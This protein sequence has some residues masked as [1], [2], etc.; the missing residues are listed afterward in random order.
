MAKDTA[1]RLVWRELVVWIFT[2]TLV[3]D[4]VLGLRDLPDIMVV[5]DHSREQ[6]V[7][8]PDAGTSFCKGADHQTMLVGLGRF[9]HQSS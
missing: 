1:R 4:E 6:R 2:P 3:F 9:D 8:A 5:A 7:A